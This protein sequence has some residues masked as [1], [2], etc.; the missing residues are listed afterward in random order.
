MLCQ[1]APLCDVGLEVRALG[2][3]PLSMMQLPPKALCGA[4]VVPEAKATRHTTRAL[5]YIRPPSATMLQVHAGIA[6]PAAMLFVVRDVVAELVPCN[7]ASDGLAP[8]RKRGV[9]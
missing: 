1:L 9:G 7:I 3:G 4:R 8:R 2:R 5:H 6:P